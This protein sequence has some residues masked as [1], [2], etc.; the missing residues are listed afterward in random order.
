MKLRAIWPAWKSR[1]SK[2]DEKGKTVTVDQKEKMI[3]VA[4]DLFSS[5]GYLKTS[6][7]EIAKGMGLTKG[8]LYYHVE[9]KEDILYLIHNEMIDAFIDTYKKNIEPEKDQKQ[10]LKNWVL[11]HIGLMRDYARHI[12]VFF[13]EFENITETDRFDE[14]VKRRDHV[15]SLLYRIIK[16]GVDAERF[17]ND[18]HPGLV[19]MLIVG[20]LNWFYQWY[21]PD[22]ELSA[23]EMAEDV[24]KIIFEGVLKRSS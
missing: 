13:N 19:T 8:G 16:E 9:K 1:L 23:E 20:M 3:E 7:A 2:Q 4:L 24:E 6:M 12:K 15:T 10:R 17:R 18:I 21:R 5:K 22:G 11:A 14:I